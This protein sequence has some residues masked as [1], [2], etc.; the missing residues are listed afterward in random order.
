MA[1]R[2]TEVLRNLDDTLK[3]LNFLTMRSCGLVLMFYS[4][5]YGAE[6]LFSAFSLLFGAAG[7]LVQFFLTG[8][9]AVALS[10]VERHEDEHYVPSAIRYYV[11]RPWRVLYAGGQT[12]PVQLDSRLREV[13]R[14]HA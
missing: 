11:S 5:F 6:L 4:L 2:Q 12:D 9:C 14:G 10:W 7:V 3:I 1:R 13:L 8:L